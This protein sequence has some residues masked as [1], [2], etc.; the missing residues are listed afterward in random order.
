MTIFE[1]FNGKK[2]NQTPDP[3]TNIGNTMSEL[4]KFA[5]DF[6]GDPE[7]VGKSMLANGQMTQDQFRKLAPIADK[8]YSMIRR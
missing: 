7:Q 4:N 1:R 6:Q 2:S 3:F 5:G 8:I